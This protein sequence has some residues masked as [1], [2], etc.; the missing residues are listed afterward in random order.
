MVLISPPALLNNVKKNY[1]FGEG[2]HPLTKPPILS[3]IADLR[4]VVIS[5]H[6]GLNASLLSKG[7][8]LQVKD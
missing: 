8:F 6:L 1:G 2:G 5:M 3:W 7:N 4:Y